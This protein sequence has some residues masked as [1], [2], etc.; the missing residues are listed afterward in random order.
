MSTRIWILFLLGLQSSLFAQPDP[1]MTF[2]G[3][4]VQSS[5]ILAHDL[6]V[7]LY[8][9][10]THQVVERVFVRGDGAFEFHQLHPGSYEVR[11]LN[12]R[13][14]ILHSEY[15]SINQGASGLTIRLPDTPISKPGGLVDVASLT[16][17][18]D[19]KAAKQLEKAQREFIRGNI[20]GA[21]QAAQEALQRDPAYGAAHNQLG[22]YYMALHQPANALTEFQKTVELDPGIPIG[23][24]NLSILLLGFNR[25]AEAEAEARRAIQL[26]PRLSKSH[27]ILGISM[28][29][30]KKFT[31]EALNH[32]RE[33]SA[34]FPLARQLSSELEKRLA[35]DGE[36]P[37][38]TLN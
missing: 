24:S 34:D 6:M 25:P 18:V 14:E 21:I 31:S 30:Q 38:K 33:A 17:P 32:L 9:Q 16:H 5:P 23:H 13:S 7:E 8:D 37:K 12:G 15:A 20:Q 2:R 19:R 27:Y 28:L 22:G 10:P 11:V 29:R 36:L 26:N 3:E 1:Y 4:V 35:A